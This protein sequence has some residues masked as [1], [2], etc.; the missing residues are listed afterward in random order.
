[1]EIYIDT[2]LVENNWSLKF[3]L[4]F[5]LLAF[6]FSSFYSLHFSA[7]MFYMSKHIFNIFPGLLTCLSQ[8]I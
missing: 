6:M 2:N 1:M 4:F 5:F 7:E 3:D 8:L